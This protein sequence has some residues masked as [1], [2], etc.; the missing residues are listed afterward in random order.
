MAYVGE[1]T[2]DFGVWNSAL[3]DAFAP[4]GMGVAVGEKIDPEYVG[5]RADA[6]QSALHDGWSGN[7][8]K[9]HFATNE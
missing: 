8:Y 6:R 5:A 3:I 9:Y 4:M 1:H 2:S 7:I